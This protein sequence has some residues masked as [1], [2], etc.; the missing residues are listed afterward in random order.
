MIRDLQFLFVPASY[1]P[2]QQRVPAFGPVARWKWIWLAACEQ[3]QFE[4]VRELM[5]KHGLWIG[6]IFGLLSV[7]LGSFGAHGL[8]SLWSEMDPEELA[9]RLANWETGN[10]YLM[11][12]ALV[13]LVV[14]MMGQF[15]RHRVLEWAMIAIAAGTVVF[16]GFLY[17]IVL[18]GQDWMG[19]IVPLG[20]VAMIAG[21]GL[22]VLAGWN[23]VQPRKK[24][25]S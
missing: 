4:F 8:Q 15:N 21:W 6:A 22:L 2:V 23:A 19:M 5:A 13:L 3:K 10:R 7:V 18:S 9:D 24:K 1:F 11:Y 14:G 16:S 17:L 25:K 20:G 12:H